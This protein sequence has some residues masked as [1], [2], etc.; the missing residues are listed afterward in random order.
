MP[1]ILY[2]VLA[3]SFV[4]LNITERNRNKPLLKW[5]IINFGIN[6]IYVADKEEKQIHSK[7]K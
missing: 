2:S 4:E 5:L 1:G 3:C 7:K 6:T